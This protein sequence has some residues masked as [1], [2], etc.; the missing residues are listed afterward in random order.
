MSRLSPRVSE[1]P[2]SAPQRLSGV[3]SHGLE[4]V[5]QAPWEAWVLHCMIL[6]KLLYFLV[7]LKGK[8][9]IPGPGAEVR[10]GYSII[11]P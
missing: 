6:K 2:L 9:T 4:L 5:R 11:S 10:W 1:K 7:C 8:V 3:G